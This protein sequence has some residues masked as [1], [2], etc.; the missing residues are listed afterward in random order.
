MK[1]KPEFYTDPLLRIKQAPTA[2]WATPE[3]EFMAHSHQCMFSA[4]GLSSSNKWDGEREEGS[5][6]ARCVT[7]KTAQ[8]TQ[9]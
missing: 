2:F 5:P 7:V 8:T 4:L 9:V 6:V 1:K 3:A